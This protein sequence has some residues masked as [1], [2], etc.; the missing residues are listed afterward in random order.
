MRFAGLTF[1]AAFGLALSAVSANATP[2][3]PGIDTQRG[4]NIV[5]VAGGC[6]PG[7]HPNQWGR[8]A[9][10]RHGYYR[11]QHAG[12]PYS[13]GGDERLNRPSPTDHTANQ[14]NQR[15][16]YRGGY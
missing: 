4:S 2:L 7:F 9:P 13:G 3:A 12:Y 14:L 11:G 8:C 6:G 10:H 5:E 1:V 15:E 16:L